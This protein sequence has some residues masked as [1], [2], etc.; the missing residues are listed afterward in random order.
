M[1]DAGSQIVR[2]ERGTARNLTLFGAKISR[3][4]PA[5]GID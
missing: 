2:E 1:L 4:P 5:I 3:E